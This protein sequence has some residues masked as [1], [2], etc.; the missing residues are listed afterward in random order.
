MEIFG[1]SIFIE[2]PP[3]LQSP[4]LRLLLLPLLD[5]VV[6]RVELGNIFIIFNQVSSFRVHGHVHLDVVRVVNPLDNLIKFRRV[7]RV[8]PGR[9]RVLYHSTFILLSFIEPIHSTSYS[10]RN[11]LSLDLLLFLTLWARV[12]VRDSAWDLGLSHLQNFFFFGLM[13]VLPLLNSFMFS[14]SDSR[15]HQLQPLELLRVLFLKCLHHLLLLLQRKDFSSLRIALL[16]RQVVHALVDVIEVG[17]CFF[18][19]LDWSR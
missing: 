2:L 4:L 13:I 16:Q 17:G 12:E 9:L 14:S 15:L 1:R 18:D 5:L 11:G 10:F 7:E 8:L 19:F 3:L 6:R